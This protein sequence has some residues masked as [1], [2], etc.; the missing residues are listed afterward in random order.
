MNIAN[1]FRTILK[2]ICQRLV[3]EIWVECI[4]LKL[5]RVSYTKN[6]K[7]S[8]EVSKFADLAELSTLTQASF[9]QFLSKFYI[10]LSDI[11]HIFEIYT[12]LKIIMEYV[13]LVMRWTKKFI[14]D[15]FSYFLNENYFFDIWKNNPSLLKLV[16]K[17]YINK[18][19]RSKSGVYNTKASL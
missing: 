14:W 3:H 10:Y 17:H 4:T 5:F 9:F 19:F 1:F 7:D 16:L 18:Y 12:V 8:R 2:N 13:D 15:L 6:C 11:A